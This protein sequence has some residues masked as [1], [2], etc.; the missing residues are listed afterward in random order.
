MHL[1]YSTRSYVA[2]LSHIP[3]SG[4]I[5]LVP[6]SV[7]LLALASG[8][9]G[10]DTPTSDGSGDD[11]STETTTASTTQSHSSS[12]S[13][14][15]DDTGTGT[16]TET[17]SSSSSGGGDTTDGE[18]GP[19]VCESDPTEVIPAV[20]EVSVELVNDTDE[21]FYFVDSAMWCLPF[22]ISSGGQDRR[23]GVGPQC[24]CECPSP[25]PPEILTLGLEPGQSHTLTWDG[26]ALAAFTRVV[27]CQGEPYFEDSCA[28]D[29]DG[30]LQPVEPGPIAM[31]IPLFT[32][33]LPMPK[34][35]QY[36]LL[37]TC[38]GDASFNVD[39]ELG[40]TDLSLTVMLSTLGPNPA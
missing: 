33:E 9:P 17:S 37:D 5:R 19:L 32:A 8:C 1:D 24:G 25:P 28:F 4:P 31:T 11:T 38:P 3:R 16:G 2:R 7:L 12:T 14:S 10:D 18:T 27:S 21:T 20:L 39:F 30:S 34:M 22:G 35:G 26:R 23:L 13:G 40:E 29:D 15:A 36:G 6:A